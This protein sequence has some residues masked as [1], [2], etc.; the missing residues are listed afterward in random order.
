MVQVSMTKISSKGQVVIPLELRE[1]LKEGDR[2]IIMKNQEQIILKKVNDFE[3]NPG[4][5]SQKSAKR[6]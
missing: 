1:G 3:K 2:F 6:F 5:T 4:F